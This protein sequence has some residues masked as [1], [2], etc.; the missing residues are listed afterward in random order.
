[1]LIYTLAKTHM[2]RY[3]YT[4]KNIHAYTYICLVSAQYP[5]TGFIHENSFDVDDTSSKCSM[6]LNS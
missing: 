3:K 6:E 1:M 4:H 2:Y 5:P